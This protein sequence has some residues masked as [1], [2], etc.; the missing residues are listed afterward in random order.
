MKKFGRVMPTW[1][2][3]GVSTFSL[4]P[5]G[6]R[7]VNSKARAAFSKGMSPFIPNAETPARGEPFPYSVRRSHR[8]LL[9]DQIVF[10]TR[11]VL[12]P[13]GEGRSHYEN[14]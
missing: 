10:W 14:Y 12:T 11:L 4:S 9:G 2:E 7:A 13:T 1:N 8:S 5:K 6:A 3:G